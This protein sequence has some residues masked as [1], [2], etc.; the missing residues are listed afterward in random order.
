LNLC[1]YLIEKGEELII[2][3]HEGEVDQK[4]CESLSKD[5]GGL[6]IE[7]HW[8]PVYIKTIIGHCKLLVSSRFHGCVSALDQGVPVIASSW[9]HKYEMLLKNYGVAEYLMDLSTDTVDKSMIQS[10]LRASTRERITNAGTSLRE[11]SMQMWNQVFDLLK[12]EGL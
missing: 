10:A 3:N 8:N 7:N 5:C 12:P 6:S 2:L 9:N 4:L 11:K 1:I